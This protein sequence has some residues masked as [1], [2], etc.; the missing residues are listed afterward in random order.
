MNQIRRQNPCLQSNKILHFHPTDNE[1]LLA[2]SRFSENKENMIVV[3]VNLDP[4]HTHSGW[5]E[6]PLNWFGINSHES[7]LMHDLLSDAKYLWH[8][9][10]NY[11]EL[12]LYHY[13]LISLK[14]ILIFIMSKILKVTN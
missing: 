8:G 14:C 7:Y 3:I 2:Y 10:R 1:Q 4:H 13:Q 9:S 11:I 6:L 5:V 12:I